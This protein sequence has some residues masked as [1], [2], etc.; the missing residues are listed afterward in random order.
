MWNDFSLFRDA[1]EKK[2]KAQI[3]TME[4]TRMLNVLC[5]L[6]SNVLIHVVKCNYV[7]WCKITTRKITTSV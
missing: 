1:K 4:C 6:M 3:A 7:Q 2:H 5:I